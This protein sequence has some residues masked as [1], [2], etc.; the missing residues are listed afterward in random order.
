MAHWVKFLPW[1]YETLSPD[2]QHLQNGKT[3]LNNCLAIF[4][5]VLWKQVMLV[6]GI[7]KKNLYMCTL[8]FQFAWMFQASLYIYIYISETTNNSTVSALIISSNG[9]VLIWGYLENRLCF[10]QRGQFKFLFLLHCVVCF[11][12]WSYNLYSHLWYIHFIQWSKCLSSLNNWG[13]GQSGDDFSWSLFIVQNHSFIQ[14]IVL[15]CYHMPGN[16]N[17]VA[18]KSKWLSYQIPREKLF[19]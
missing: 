1:A 14:K 6:M 16:R 11:W 12:K 5:V 15:N 8:W 4:F 3:T 10:L 19:G 18:D 2:P 17:T 9:N 7:W 13:L